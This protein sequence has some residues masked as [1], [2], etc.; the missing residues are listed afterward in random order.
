MAKMKDY[1]TSKAKAL[2]ARVEKKEKPVVNKMSAPVNKE[3]KG[4]VKDAPTRTSPKKYGAGDEKLRKD[5]ANVSAAQLKASGLSL[6]S[7]MN[8]W[9]KT[10]KRPGS[11]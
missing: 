4:S 11:K 9:N 10:G 7:Y 2:K 8:Q 3:V 6:R 5:K 1:D